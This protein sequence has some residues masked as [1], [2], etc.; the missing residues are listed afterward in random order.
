MAGIKPAG[1]RANADTRT[2]GMLG[3]GAA[4][5]VPASVNRFAAPCC[6]VLSFIIMVFIQRSLFEVTRTRASC[7]AMEVTA[8]SS[9]VRGSWAA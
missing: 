9:L 5:A 2:I 8:V 7:V 6:I 3:T 4:S 1:F